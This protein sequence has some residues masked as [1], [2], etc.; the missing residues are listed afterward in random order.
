M[1]RDA[2]AQSREKMSD[3]DDTTY[4]FRAS[5]QVSPIISGATRW[6]FNYTRPVASLRRGLAYR[7]SNIS[8]SVGRADALGVLSARARARSLARVARAPRGKS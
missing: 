5:E 1:K 3:G 7:W 4:A 2:H 6:Q 8:K